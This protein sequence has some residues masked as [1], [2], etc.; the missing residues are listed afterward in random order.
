MGLPAEFPTHTTNRSGSC[1]TSLPSNKTWSFTLSLGCLWYS[2][3]Y[4]FCYIKCETWEGKNP[5]T[6]G[7]L[8]LLLVFLSI[9]EMK[10]SLKNK[11]TQQYGC[12]VSC[13]CLSN[14]LLSLPRLVYTLVEK[15]SRR[16]VKVLPS[17]PFGCLICVVIVLFQSVVLYGE[18]IRG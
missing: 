10:D 13:S 7:W 6:L 9:G 8:W 5:I 3:I 15:G 14:R 2:Q 4:F 11:Q 18:N 17:C 16:H 12:W 1:F